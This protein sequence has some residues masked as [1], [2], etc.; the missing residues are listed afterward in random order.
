M[1]ILDYVE[2]VS[3]T[4]RGFQI[5]AHQVNLASSL[6]YVRLD[7]LIFFVS[8]L[9]YM[10]FFSLNTNLISIQSFFEQSCSS[11]LACVS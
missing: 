10:T 1:R 7:I 6:F 4:E 5:D 8:I 2:D 3:H 11:I 9:V